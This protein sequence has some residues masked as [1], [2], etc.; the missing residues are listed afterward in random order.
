[1]RPQATRSLRLPLRFDAAALHQ[2][3]QKMRHEAWIAHYND[4]AHEGD[5]RCIPLRSAAGQSDNIL[6]SADAN[7]LDTPLLEGA[8]HLRA[9]LAQFDCEM[10]AVRLMSLAAGARILPHRDAGG[11]FEDGVARLH[12]PVQTDPRVQFEIDGESVHFGLGECWYMNANC[13]HAVRNESEIERIHLVLDCVPNDW[14]RALF[15]GAGWRENPAPAYGDPNMTD[16]NIQQ[17]IAALRTN[18]APAAQTLLADLLKRLP[19]QQQACD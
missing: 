7:F 18:P 4:R 17:V 13:L 10:I 14:L 12:I 6:A 15:I 16:A 3:V 9:A 11:G 2:D 5:W 1:M 8:P 19:S